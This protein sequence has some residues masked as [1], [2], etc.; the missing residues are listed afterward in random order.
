MMSYA[1]QYLYEV[2]QIVKL[3]DRP[4]IERMAL[5]LR[6]TYIRY[7]RLFLLGIGGSAANAAHAVNDFRKML[8]F[9]AYAPSD[10]ISELTARVNDEN[11]A[12]FFRE[13]LHT[14][15]LTERD[16]VFVLS[17]SGGNA[18]TSRTI[19]LA[20]EYAKDLG[21]KVIAVVGRDDGYTAKVADEC[22]VVPAFSPDRIAAHSES[23]QAIIWHL[24][25]THP[26]LHLLRNTE[27]M[28]FS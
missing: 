2:E 5:I 21:A 18:T 14:S 27:R 8:G 25:A 9:E 19:V 6:D 1:Q 4:T 12:D 15:R 23:V 13:W 3:L 26:A 17:V 28:N 24:L 7:G 10:N 20:V 22:L 11:W 16:L